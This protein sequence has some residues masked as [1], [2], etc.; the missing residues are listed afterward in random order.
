MA[1]TLIKVSQLNR[2][3][4][5]LLES[6]QRLTELYVRGEISNF[7]ASYAGHFYFTLKDTDSSV[8]CV[9]FAKFASFLRFIPLNAMA[10]VVRANATI[11]ERD[12]S[13]Q[14]NINDMMPDGEGALEAAYQQLKQKLTDEGLFAED[15]KRP[16]PVFPSCIGVVTSENGAAIHDIVHTIERR[17]PAVTLLFSPALVQGD[18]TS[19]SI[20]RAIEDLNIDGKSQVII[21]GRGGG[22]REDL[23]AF[24]EERTVRAIA[25]SKIPV[26]S[27]VGH[28]SD[29]T[30]CDFAADVR[31]ATPTAAAEIAVPVLAD[32]KQALFDA[33][34][35]LHDNIQRQMDLRQKQ[36]KDAKTA[37][38][39]N[40]PQVFIDINRQ[41][42]NNLIQS[43]YILTSNRLD[44]AYSAFN[45]SI[46]LLDAVSPLKILA[47]GYSITEFQGHVLTGKANLKS[48]DLIKTTFSDGS[49]FSM[50]TKEQ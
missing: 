27:A 26:I 6:D 35:R 13:F 45:H 11:Y 17:F 21:V 16:L 15:K 14:L 3:V 2:Y 12:G 38:I 20:A 47:R 33:K 34:Q 43:M 18:R 48:G 42:L 28:E 39:L 25:A 36:L 24:N 22:S 23:W 29:W 44:S 4:K 40:N 46:K 9:M 50:I 49:V 19:E 8:R 41:K 31:A 30:L 10:V 1:L 32:I 5:S 7:T 37:P